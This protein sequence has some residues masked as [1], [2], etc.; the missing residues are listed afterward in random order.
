M[1]QDT[2]VSC[3]IVQKFYN[4]LVIWFSPIFF[5]DDEEEIQDTQRDTHDER[6]VDLPSY[7]DYFNFE[8]S[9]VEVEETE[10]CEVFENVS[11]TQEELN[12]PEPEFDNQ[13][14]NEGLNAH[15]HLSFFKFTKLKPHEDDFVSVDRSDE[16]C[17]ELLSI[18]GNRVHCVIL[19]DIVPDVGKGNPSKRTLF[20]ILIFCPKI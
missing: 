3:Y 1:N 12:L 17:W 4:Y 14:K 19:R 15:S 9:Q 16:Y 2:V 20:E 10:E 11:S 6:D 7:E 8:N 5:T 18:V 13:Q